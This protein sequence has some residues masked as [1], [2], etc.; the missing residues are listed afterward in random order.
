MKRKIVFEVDNVMPSLS[1]VVSVVNAKNVSPILDCVLIQTNKENEGDGSLAMRLIAS[2]SEVWLKGYAYVDGESDKNVSI[3][4]DAKTITQTLSNLGGEE[5][6]M[7]IDDTKKT[8]ECKYGTG[9]FSIPYQDSDVFPMP[10]LNREER[11]RVELAERVFCNAIGRVKYAMGNEKVYII[12]NTIHMEFTQNGLLS[13]ATDK[14]IIAE[15]KD[16]AYS[17]EEDME[18][19]IPKK[20]SSILSNILEP[21]SEGN[22]VITYT[23]NNAMIQSGKFCLTTSLLTY[24]YPEFREA[25]PSRNMV[26]AE[27]LID[28]N[29]M[30]QALKRMSP[31]ISSSDLIEFSFERNN[32]KMQS[33][34]SNLNRSTSE[35]VPCEY[36]GNLFR[37]CLSCGCVTSILNSLGTDTIKMSFTSS[38]K[39]CFFEEVGNEV[40]TE[41]MALLMPMMKMS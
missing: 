17:S 11:K 23:E 9:R 15:Y 5:I 10:I 29:A 24:R 1:A 21:K 18:I 40:K 16:N 39:P 26:T 32:M 2:D 28:K 31:V 38:R 41:Y 34:D 8:V 4:V 30:M 3:C 33:D 7:Y 37:I 36:D 27:V 25:T 12:F 13:V 6:T 35:D 22:V 19:T 14:R 20:A